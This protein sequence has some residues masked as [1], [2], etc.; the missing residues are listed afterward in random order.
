ML[1]DAHGNKVKFFGIVLAV[2]S[3]LFVLSVI[4]APILLLVG[5]S[6]V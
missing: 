2:I 3:G 1:K 4:A 5:Q 6:H